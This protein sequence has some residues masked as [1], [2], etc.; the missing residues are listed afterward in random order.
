ML[1][2][3]LD[4]LDNLDVILDQFLIYGQTTTS[5]VQSTPVPPRQLPLPDDAAPQR[6]P[7]WPKPHTEAATAATG[8]GDS[9]ASPIGGMGLRYSFGLGTPS[10]R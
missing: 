2:V 5:I 6:L 1:K 8:G 4:S 7:A 3:R 10:P 9:G